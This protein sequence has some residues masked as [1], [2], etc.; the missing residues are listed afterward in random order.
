MERPAPLRSDRSADAPPFRPLVVGALYPGIERGLT[1]DLIATRALGGQ[2][3]VVCTAHVMAGHGRVTDVLEVPSDA[4]A[5]QFEHLAATHTPTAVKIGIAGGVASIRAIARALDGLPSDVPVVLDLTLSGPSGEDIAEGGTREAL[6]ALFP[7]LDLVTLR[8]VDAELVCGMEIPTL[9]DAQV[10]VQRLHRLGGARVL[11]RCGRIA[12]SAFEPTS[13]TLPVMRDLYYDGDD[14]ALFETPEVQ[15][16]GL[17]G[18]SS[19][20]TLA[21]A[22]GLARGAG[23]VEALQQAERLTAEALRGAADASYPDYAAGVAAEAG[24]APS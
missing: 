10:A 6:V 23:A 20:L 11:L 7:R 9:D 12:D 13:E 5:A 1:A 18:A 3:L 16:P 22:R 24:L 8:R 2:A 19:L 15:A 14:F 17:H 4:V 21:V